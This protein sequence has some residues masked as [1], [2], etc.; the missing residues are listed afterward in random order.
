MDSQR[1]SDELGWER[2]H[3]TLLCAE[4]ACCP[5]RTHRDRFGN[6]VIP[7]RNRDYAN[8]A[9]T[10]VLDSFSVARGFGTSAD[11]RILQMRDAK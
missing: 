8:M 1:S 5:G 4:L 9:T 6:A 11:S 10:S 3:R 2:R 7:A